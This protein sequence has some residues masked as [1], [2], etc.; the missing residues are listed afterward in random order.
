VPTGR[1]IL[2]NGLPGSGKTTVARSLQ[3]HFDKP[4]LRLGSDALRAAVPD[5]WTVASPGAGQVLAGL[6]RAVRALADDGNDVIVDD[7]ILQRAWLL[8]WAA[9]LTG[10]DAWLV[11]VRCPAAVARERMRLRGDQ[12]GGEG[13]PVDRLPAVH[14][15]SDYDVEVDT[16][17]A[18]P[19]H[20]ARRIADHVA[21]HRPRVMRRLGR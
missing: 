15:H 19:D 2:L 8:D 4:W 7:V 12:A 18:P 16:S 20:C 21:A 10:V 9:V 3:A 1:I 13:V 11:G 5:G 17:L 6:R 14:A